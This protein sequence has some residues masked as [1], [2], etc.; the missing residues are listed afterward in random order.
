MDEKY[1]LKLDGNLDE[2]TIKQNVLKLSK[3]LNYAN[4]KFIRPYEKKY[5]EDAA[6][7]LEARGYPIIKDVI[8][9]VFEWMK[10]MNWPGA[11]IAYDILKKLP[12]DILVENLET[13]IQKAIST[14]DIGWLYWLNLFLEDGI[15]DEKKISNSSL[16]LAIKNSEG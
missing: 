8:L 10:D 12:E 16:L 3:D 15:V 11:L 1:Y 4:S 6:K 9:D 2:R 14:N 13:S 7:V 5:W